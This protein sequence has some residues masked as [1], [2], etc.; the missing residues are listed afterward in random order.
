[1]IGCSG[2]AAKTSPPTVTPCLY[3]FQRCRH[4]DLFLSSR[5]NCCPF[6][7]LIIC[8]LMPIGYFWPQLV[9][10]NTEQLLQRPLL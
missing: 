7:L 6:M 8:E 9:I 10:M 2:D 1:M 5:P 4:L 3:I